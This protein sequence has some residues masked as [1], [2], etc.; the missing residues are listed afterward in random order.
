MNPKKSTQEKEKEVKPVEK[1]AEKEKKKKKEKKEKNEDNKEAPKKVSGLKEL[2]ESNDDKKETKKSKKVKKPKEKKPK[3]EYALDFIMQLKDSKFANEDLL[4]SKEV[5][6]HFEHFKKDNFEVKKMKSGELDKPSTKG[7][8]KEELSKSGHKTKNKK[9][10]SKAEEE[11]KKIFGEALKDKSVEEK[12]NY[13]LDKINSDNYDFVRKEILEL[14]KDSTE[15]QDKFVDA[16]IKTSISKAPFSEIYAK[17]CKNLDKDL[18][19][20]IGEDKKA[21]SKMKINLI[22][23]TRNL[24]NSEQFDDIDKDAHK[25]EKENKL[26]KNMI[27]ITYFLIELI[28]LHIISK[29]VVPSCFQNL[30]SKYEKSKNDEILK[31][32]YIEA[33]LIFT[34]EFEKM[35]LSQ[36]SKLG[37]KEVKEYTDNINENIKKLEK[38][39]DEVNERYIKNKITNFI[40]KRKKNYEKTKFEIY[41]EKRIKQVPVSNSD[42]KFSQDVINDRIE[43]GLSD[44]INF[45]E[46]EGASDKYNWN[47]ETFLIEKKGHG[48]DDILEAYFISCGNIAENDIKQAK[49]YIKELLEYYIGQ[50]I[51]ID[52]KDLKNRLLK[53]FEI[54]RNDIPIINDAFS[55]AINIFLENELM[56]IIDLETLEEENNLSKEELII[57]DKILKNVN[58]NSKDKRLKE[59]IARLKFVESNKDIFKW[60]FD[61]GKKKT[62]WFCFFK[63]K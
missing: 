5:L 42:N 30:F 7:K 27:G 24:F 16:I 63:K 4:L 55:H 62:K 17:L 29:K 38:I 59:E 15:I 51:G 20:K 14:I 6:S 2:L 32:I 46:K 50:N 25:Y 22:D 12:I 41:L 49:N 58:D 57:M 31:N 26:K 39:R 21:I 1:E 23:K 40:E 9:E 11:F 53:M 13:Y 34:E 19:Q 60:L 54:V 18:P 35:I 43:K 48:L 45:V 28:K 52:K 44:Y 56:K 33:I 36:E 3:K 37:E 61:D 8:S 47:D 10:D